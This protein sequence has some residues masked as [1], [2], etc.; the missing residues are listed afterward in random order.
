MD[1]IKAYIKDKY[2][3]SNYQMAQL[4]FVFK[5]VSS[6]LSKTLIMG[7]VFHNHLKLYA[8]LLFIMCFIRTFSG[9]L[10]F[11]TYYRCLA[12]STLYIGSIIF[13]FS[14]IVLPLYIQLL[15]LVTCIIGC[16]ITG[17]VLSKYRT[18]FPK[19]QLYFSRNI[20]CLFIFIYTI[21]LYII[22]EKSY[23]TVGTWM[24]ILHSLQ[25][26]VAK[27]VKKGENIS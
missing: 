2:E 21:I 15:L 24:I 16:Y 8:F 20:T 12:A 25:L 13:V 14:K 11:S 18:D 1:K 23:F 3:L 6:E 4:V 10:H 22:P 5:T 17:P 26:I 19:K 7:I 9:G 27:I